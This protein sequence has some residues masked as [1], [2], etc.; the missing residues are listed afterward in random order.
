MA[1]YDALIA[2][3]PTVAGANTTEKLETLRATM[4]TGAA[5]PMIIPAYIIYNAIVPSEFSALTNA[6]QALV[7]DILNQGTV[8]GT[9]GKTARTV[10]LQVFGAATTTRANLAAIAAPYDTPQ[11]PWLTANGYPMTLN[12]NDLRAAGLI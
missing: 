9:Q 7:R 3:W 2:E 8:D 11:I 10:M 12:E 6:N 4:V 1:Y 5:I